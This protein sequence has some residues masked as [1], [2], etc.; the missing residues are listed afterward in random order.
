SD[1]V[2]QS[3]FE[4]IHIDDRAMFRRQLHFALDPNLLDVEAD[5]TQNSSDITKN[6]VT[7][8]PQHIPPENS[9]F[10]E[11]S[12]MCRFRCLLDNSSGFLVRSYSNRQIYMINEYSFYSMF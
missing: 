9:S 8:D 1:V 7:Y 4:F 6:I 10:L 12:F 3:V 5:G 2:H 11:R